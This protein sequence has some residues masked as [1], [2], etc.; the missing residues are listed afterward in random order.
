MVRGRG[1]RASLTCS[2]V[3]NSPD[4]QDDEGE[5][6]RIQLEGC[7]APEA[8]VGLCE[9]RRYVVGCWRVH[10]CIECDGVVAVVE[11]NL[12]RSLP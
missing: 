8:G 2:N 7:L 4:S 9:C 12:C 10:C 6:S 3:L 5:S 11:V 1:K